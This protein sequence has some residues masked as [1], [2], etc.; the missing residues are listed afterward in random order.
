MAIS[1]GALESAGIP[2]LTALLLLAPE[3]RGKANGFVIRKDRKTTGM[4]NLIEGEVGEEPIVLIDDILNSGASAEKARAVIEATGRKVSRLFTVIDYHS[5]KG[6]FWRKAKKIEVDSLFS[7]A[8]FG[9]KLHRNPPH[10]AQSYRLLW[11]KTITGGFPYYLV[12]KSTPLLV[13][14]TIYRGCDAGKMH[15]FDA[16]TG[17]ILWEH[18]A[19]GAFT[20]KGVW[21]S[22]AVHA[23]RLFY[24]AYNG[25]VYARDAKTGDEIWSQA[26]CECLAACRS[27]TRLDLH[28]P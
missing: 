20:L 17:E 6:E 7:L 28:W 25:V 10:P 23:G 8:D 18:S 13:G 21:S 19:Q 26:R 11:H 15:A 12:P 1:N 16:G 3:E 4:G 5:A 24:G 14:E 22:P 9:L 2:L 27:G